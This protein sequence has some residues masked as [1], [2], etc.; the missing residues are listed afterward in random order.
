MSGARNQGGKWSRDGSPRSGGCEVWGGQD[1][2]YW[3][4]A[5]SRD[6]KEERKGLSTFPEKHFQAKER[7]GAMVGQVPGRVRGTACHGLEFCL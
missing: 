1:R 7:V 2:L 6:A 4:V 3:E 5:L